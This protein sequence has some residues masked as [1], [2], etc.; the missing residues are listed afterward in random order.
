MA[1]DSVSAHVA[2][3]QKKWEEYPA[4]HGVE[5]LPRHD[6][7]A[8]RDDARVAGQ[9]HVPASSRS[10]TRRCSGKSAVVATAGDD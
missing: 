2:Q 1:E 6:G 9:I 5:K 7:R 8:H 4:A 10:T 3:Q